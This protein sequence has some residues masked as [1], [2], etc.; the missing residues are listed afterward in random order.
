MTK[1][2]ALFLL[3]TAIV[4]LLSV[5]ALA[6]GAT[7]VRGVCKD[8]NG[9]PVAGAAVEFTNLDNGNKTTLKTDSHGQYYSIAVPAG[10]YKI[11]L[12]MAGGK[13]SASIDHV[14]VQASAENVADFAAPAQAQRQQDEKVK[15][16]NEK[17]G[18]LN[19]LLKQAAQQKSDK[20]YDD[21]VATMERAAAQ[22]QS[23]DVIYAS[24]ADAYA[25]DK[26]FPQAEAAYTKAIALAPATSKSLAA[27]HA[28]LAL[29]LLQ[30]G[31]I[32]PGM[33][34]CAKAAQLDPTQAGQCYY[35]EGAILTNQG[36]ADAANQAFDRSIAADPTRADAYYQKGVNLLAKAT[37]GKDNK[38]VAVPGTA[39]AL[40]RYLE[41]APDGKYAQSA[42]DL[43]ASIGAS[44]QASFGAQKKGK[45]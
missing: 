2:I 14:A 5:A 11:T 44:V 36:N 20:Q 21:A 37:L 7:I 39:E 19:A 22:D 38:M 25:L 17:I 28:G 43:L 35:N 34:E 29:V 33:D 8:E 3:V 27:Y 1:R 23:H 6:Q 24:L 9:K 26:K 40:N 30:Q 42:R 10:T 12:T 15:Q 18:S 4:A 13:A 16:E 41:L 31:K 45:K 32:E